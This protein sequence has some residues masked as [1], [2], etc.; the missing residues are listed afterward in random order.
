MKGLSDLFLQIFVTLLLLGLEYG[1]YRYISPISLEGQDYYYYGAGVLFLL[2]VCPAAKAVWSTMKEIAHFF[3][4]LM[5][6]ILDRN[7]GEYLMIEATEERERK[8]KE[9][10]ASDE[11][12]QQQLEKQHLE[13]FYTSGKCSDDIYYLLG[14]QEGELYGKIEGLQVEYERSYQEGVS[15]YQAECER[16]RRKYDNCGGSPE[17]TEAQK[18]DEWQQKVNDE[19]FRRQTRAREAGDP[20]WATK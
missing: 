12:K 5:L 2:L 8:Q 16:E 19:A 4:W 14:R 20:Y 17:K 9:W 13:E 1:L 18:L 7:P 15:A 11:Y 3:H 10:E 6:K